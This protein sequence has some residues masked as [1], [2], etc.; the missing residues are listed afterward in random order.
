MRM[1]GKLRVLL[2]LWVLG[3][4]A[5][6]QGAAPPE[7]YRHAYAVASRER[8]LTFPADHGPHRDASYE[9]WYFTGH[10]LTADG[11]EDGGFEVTVFRISPS[12]GPSA[13][14]SAEVSQPA[15]PSY[16]SLHVAASDFTRGT[17]RHHS[18]ALRERPGIAEITTAPDAPL[19]IR[20]PGTQIALAAD[21]R[22]FSIDSLLG[23]SEADA[24]HLRATLASPKPVT[25]HGE[26]GYS[27]KGG[28]PTCASHYSSFPRLLG[29]AS[30]TGGA[31]ATPP[32]Q[33]A[34]AWFDHEFGT[35]SLGRPGGGGAVGWDWFAIQLTD[36]WDVMLDQMRDERGRTVHTFGSLVDPAGA[37]TALAP[38]AIELRPETTWVSPHTGARYPARWHVR[39]RDAAHP[40]DVTLVPRLADQELSGDGSALATYWEGSCDVI[41]AGG[42]A[43]RCVGT[44]YVEMT[45]YDAAHRPRF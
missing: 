5:C 36:G 3:G 34:Q 29:T 11:R 42:S 14:M 17:F 21:G 28:C 41:A 32:A 33:Q 30:V 38:D 7:P 40:L 16:L 19:T 24:L 18:L 15:P 4:T 26:R 35:S 37:V 10:L 2:G 12:A 13:G 25:L 9:W 27:W 1:L 22:T 45:G 43:A 23:P 20:L 44:S 6:K 8:A 39:V 31:P